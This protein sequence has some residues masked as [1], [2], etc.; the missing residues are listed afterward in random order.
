MARPPAMAGIES[1][2]A[3]ETTPLMPAQPTI[4]GV[5]LPGLRSSATLIKRFI[6]I[7]I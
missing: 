7:V 1:A 2:A 4:N 3:S 6:N 5:A